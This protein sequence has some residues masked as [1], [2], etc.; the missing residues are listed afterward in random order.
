MN[1]YQIVTLLLILSVLIALYLYLYINILKWV[2]LN[3][4]LATIK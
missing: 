1:N 4:N 3:Y 2:Q